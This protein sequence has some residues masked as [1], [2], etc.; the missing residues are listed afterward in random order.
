[1]RFVCVNRVSL[2]CPLCVPAPPGVILPVPAP[3]GVFEPVPGTGKHLASTN[4]VLEPGTTTI[5]QAEPWTPEE[6][7]VMTARTDIE[8][9]REHAIIIDFRLDRQSRNYASIIGLLKPGS[10]INAPLGRQRGSMGLSSVGCFWLDTDNKAHSLPRFTVDDIVSLEW[11]PS[12]SGVRP[13][14]KVTFRVNGKVP[15]VITEKDCK[16][17]FDGWTVALSG[18]WTLLQ[19]RNL[20]A[21]T[22]WAPL[23]EFVQNGDGVLGPDELGLM[24][25]VAAAD[26][27]GE[28]LNEL[29][30][31]GDGALDPDELVDM[32]AAADA[33]AQDDDP[34]LEAK[35]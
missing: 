35:A 3:P 30:K 27:E 21:D 20:D 12:M 19:V 26:G 15:F 29:D 17:T 33:D 18:W 28:P 32:I 16:D 1:M 6:W 23:N 22:P 31:I 9:T 7:S 24:M 10:S 2:V 11:R 25:S 5:P 13:T 8:L 14:G 34:D 4:G